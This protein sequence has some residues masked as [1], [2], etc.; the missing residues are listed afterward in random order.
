M[1][2]SDRGADGQRFLG[3]R[4]PQG[5]PLT[6]RTVLIWFASFFAVVIGVNALMA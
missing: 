4:Q 5:R 1:T 6:G 3:S 2:I